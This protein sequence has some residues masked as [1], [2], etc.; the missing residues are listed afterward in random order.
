MNSQAQ[1]LDQLLNSSYVEFNQLTSSN[2]ITPNTPQ[3]IFEIFFKKCQQYHQS[4]VH[5]LQEMKTVR[6]TKSKGDLFELFCQRY[7]KV[8]KEYEKVWLLKELP[9][10][11][12]KELKLPLGDKDYG[13][14]LIALKGGLYSAV[15]CKF[16]APR[17]PIRVTNKRNEIKTIYSAVNWKELTT[18]NELCNASGPWNERITMTTA[19][20]VRR[21][22]GIK[23]KR[24]RSICIKSFQS[25]SAD[26]WVKLF[27]SVSARCQ[28]PDAR[29]REDNK[30]EEP[31]F[32]TKKSHY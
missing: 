1:I 30:K 14:D 26:H 29:L 8:L 3:S 15:Q 9:D 2:I 13:I 11:L 16:K 18:F 27:E 10:D 19:P 24:D 31:C 28:E 21:L 20:S 32:P 23:D 4:P 25:I 5:S 6:S 7:L 22:G 12:K 17:G